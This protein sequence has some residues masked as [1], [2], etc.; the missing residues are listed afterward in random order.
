MKARTNAVK[1][2]LA[3]GGTSIGTMVFEFASSGIARI[4]ASAGAEFVIYDMEHTGWGIDTI[5]SLMAWSR[6]AETVPLVRV[7]ATQ[8]HLLS[9]PLDAGAMGLVVP[10][11]ESEEQARLIVDSAKYYPLGNRG[12]GFGIAHDDYADHLGDL[13]EKMRRANDEQLLIVQIETKRGVEQADRIAAVEGI[14]VLWIGPF[15]LTTSL[16]VPSQYDHPA[17]QQAIA[18]VLAA[19]ERHGKSAGIMALGLDHARAVLAQ[20]FRCVAY[21]GDIWLYAQALKQGI[22]ALRADADQPPA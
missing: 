5:R 8:Y 6:A 20:G 16:G 17:Y 14:D 9:G 2:T 22:A 4:A 7:P 13:S 1:Q 3:R 19:C 10:L 18:D 11:V 15:D 12:T 21:W